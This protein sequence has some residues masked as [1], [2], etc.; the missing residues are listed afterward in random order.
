[1]NIK[2]KLFIG[3][4]LLCISLN[5]QNK[6]D[7]LYINVNLKFNQEDFKL[8]L[9]YVSIQKDTLSF[10][11]VKFYLTSFQ[12][13]FKDNSIYSENNSYYLFDVENPETIQFSIANHI[14]KEIKAIKFNI[15]VNSLTSV[16]GA[17]E[18]DLDAIKGM[19]W[20]WQ[21]G[22]IKMK[23]EGKS[24]SCKTRKNKFQFHVGGYLEPYYAMR[25]VNINCNSNDKKSC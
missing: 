13:E 17:M 25:N 20:A 23:I 14:D 16:S 3:L 19:Y 24:S 18:G 21:S 5:A 12:L 1:M 7:R 8:K 15:G 2:F 6:I 10:E 22:F 11:T 9:N 4:F